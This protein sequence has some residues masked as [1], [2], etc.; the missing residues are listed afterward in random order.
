MKWINFLHFYQPANQQKDILEAVVKQSYFPIL[1]KISSLENVNLSINITGSLLELFERDGYND[2]LNLLRDSVTK[3]KIELTGSCKF[4]ALI[5]LIPEEEIKRQILQNQATINKILGFEY[6]PKG[7]FP[8]EMAYHP[9]LD[10]IIEEMGFEWIIMDEIAFFQKD[11]HNGNVAT[12]IY[13]GKQK[14]RTSGNRCAYRTT[15]R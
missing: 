5:P 6:K 3:G 12:T 9:K 1:E 11:S 4:H 8:P 7:F 2:L 13:F 14:R 15:A 10:K